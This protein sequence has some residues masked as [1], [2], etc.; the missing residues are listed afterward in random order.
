MLLGA[1]AFLAA[2]AFGAIQIDPDTYWHIIAGRWIL[3]HGHVPSHDMFSFTRHGAPWMAQEWGAEVIYAFIY[4]VAGWPGVT[5]LTAL[6]FGLTIAYLSRFLIA[7][8]EPLYVVLLSALAGF[9]MSYYMLVRPHELVWPLAALWIG[10][11]IDHSE[12]G[13]GPPWWL[14]SVML[15]WVNLHGSYILG[16]GLAVMIGL[17]AS[18]TAGGDWKSVSWHWIGFMVAAFG[19]ALLNPRG[20]RLLIFPFQLLDMH[21]LRQLADWLPTNLARLPVMGVWLAA[22]LGLAFSGR[23]RLSMVRAVTL[24][25][26]T[27]FALEYT[28]NVSLLGLISPFLIAAPLAE[29]FRL[30]PSRTRLARAID[31]AGRIF[32]RR[33]SITAFCSTVLVAGVL[34]A[35]FVTI[36]KPRPLK[37]CTPRAALHVLLSENPRARIFNDAYFGGYLIFHGVPVFVDPRVDVYG[38][39]FLRKYYD[40]L[41]LNPH[42]D[43]TAL[44][45]RYRIDAILVGPEWPVVKL[46]D[47]LPDWQRIYEDRVA[48]VYLRRPG[49]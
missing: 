27:Y 44:L 19:C 40:A 46:L 6:S 48:V 49:R 35:V 14:L 8:M 28:R 10:T 12:S 47:R 18:V 25:G 42:G 17:D 22:V 38:D 41:E 43:I 37:S 16:L 21:V 23:V 5:L 20:W 36:Y 32:P 30:S 33:S 1:L 7:R 15:L 13:R 4:G 9:M 31:A 45:D 39:A 24:V 2:L 3:T 29:Q 34:G 11:L 26:L